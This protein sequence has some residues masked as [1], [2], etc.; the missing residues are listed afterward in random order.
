MNLEIFKLRSLKLITKQVA[1]Y[2]ADLKFQQ[3]HEHKSNQ[4]DSLVGTVTTILTG[5]FQ[6]SGCH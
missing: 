3:L 4:V 1:N 5:T 6:A 2:K